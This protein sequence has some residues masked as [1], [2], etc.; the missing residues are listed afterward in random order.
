MGFIIASFST[1]ANEVCLEDQYLE[2]EYATR[3]GVVHITCRR[4]AGPIDPLIQICGR[5]L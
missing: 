1:G 5:G 3:A 2:A 4:V